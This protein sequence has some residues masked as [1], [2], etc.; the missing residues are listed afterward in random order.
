MSS[1]THTPPAAGEH[2][3]RMTLSDVVAGL[4]ARGSSE[5]HSVT[6][7]RDAK[8]ETNIEV[9]VRTSDDGTIRTPAEA[10]VAA[11]AVYDRLRERYPFGAGGEGGA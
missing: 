7:K 6:L 11:Q 2:G 9:I 5:H 4:L 1:R 8:G 3:R 10:E